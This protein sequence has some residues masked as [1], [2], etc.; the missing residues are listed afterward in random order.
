MYRS[1]LPLLSALC[2]AAL[3]R[4]EPTPAVSPAMA[5]DAAKLTKLLHDFLAG[6]SRNDIAMHDRFWADD[7]IYTGSSGRR[8]GK[9]EIMK[10]VREEAAKPASAGAET[11][12]YT[13][14]D[15]RIQQYGTTAIVAFRLIGTTQKGEKTEVANYLNSGT[16]LKR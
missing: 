16:F 14:E 4:A 5:P 12:T 13:A 3:V 8:L 11:A 6:A 2:L 7:L 9:A 10:D 1:L 15:I